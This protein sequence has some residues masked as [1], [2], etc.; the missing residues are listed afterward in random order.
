[1][2]APFRIAAA[3]FAVA[4]LTEVSF[5]QTERLNPNPLLP[6][7]VGSGPD[8]DRSRG[9]GGA[10]FGRG[11]GPAEGPLDENPADTLLKE[12]NGTNNSRRTGSNLFLDNRRR[13]SGYRGVAPKFEGGAVRFDRRGS[14]EEA[15]YGSRPGSYGGVAR[16]TSR[17]S[18]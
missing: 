9:G 10:P 15:I 8:V 16:K 11:V 3:L 2:S 12:I 1:M 14:Y 7:G 6:S 17:R 5:G 18:P 4:V 13:S